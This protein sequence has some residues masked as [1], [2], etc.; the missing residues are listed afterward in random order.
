M[1]KKATSRKGKKVYPGLE[2]AWAARRRNAALRRAEKA[3][4]GSKPAAKGRAATSP[5]GLTGTAAAKA[6]GVSKVTLYRRLGKLGIKTRG[7]GFT[8]DILDRLRGG[9][10]AA[11]VTRVPTSRRG[12]KPAAVVSQS[13]RATSRD[14]MGAI[15]KVIDRRLGEFLAIIREH[16][17]ESRR[18]P[19]LRIATD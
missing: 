11:P 13:V 3:R 5:R 1:A 16:L 10:G 4:A 19:V 18:K 14:D 7:T 12:R 17:Q 8:P 2:K 15:A 6:L 9:G